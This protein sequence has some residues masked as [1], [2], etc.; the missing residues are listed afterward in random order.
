MTSGGGKKRDIVTAFD[1]SL[2]QHC[3]H[4]LDP[5][6]AGGGYRQPGGS[7]HADPQSAFGR[8]RHG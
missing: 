3:H 1:Q 7:N 5:A 4:P 2:D 6:V 8:M